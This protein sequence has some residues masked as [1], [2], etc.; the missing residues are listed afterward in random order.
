MRRNLQA[1]GRGRNQRL[2]EVLARGLDGLALSLAARSTGLLDLGGGARGLAGRDLVERVELEHGLAVAQRIA[3]E[4]GVL[5]AHLGGA[6][7][8]LDL[9]RVDDAGD[10]RVGHLATRQGEALLLEARAAVGAVHAVERGEGGA[11][12]HDEA[13]DVSTGSQLQQV[14]AVHGAQLHAGQ[15]AEGLHQSGVLLAVVVDH[16]RAATLHVATVAH[17]ALAGADAAAGL[18]LLHIVVGTDR[19]ENGHGLAGLLHVGQ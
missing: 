11:G 3:L 19:L 13:A 18:H 15:V 17:L 5:V 14:Q 6:K 12:P 9:V 8:A 1:G 7:D 10:V 2:V 16:E 4:L